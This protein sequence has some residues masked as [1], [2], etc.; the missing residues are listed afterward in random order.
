MTK[1]TNQ[2]SVTKPQSGHTPGPWRVNEDTCVIAGHAD[3]PF[4][5]AQV[6]MGSDANARLIAAAPDLLRA[7][8]LALGQLEGSKPLSGVH[9]SSLRADIE[10]ARAA[11]AKAKGGAQ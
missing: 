3:A 8:E 10:I 9:A 1:I 2:L 5:V 7:L 6:Y 4:A 11:I